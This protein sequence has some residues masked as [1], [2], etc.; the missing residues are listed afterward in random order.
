[1]AYPVG[2][3]FDE[4]KIPQPDRSLLTERCI[5][6]GIEEAIDVAFVDAGMVEE[7]L[8][9]DSGRMGG[10][11]LEAARRA[12]PMVAG[13]ARAG[14]LKGGGG[15]VVSGEGPELVQASRPRDPLPG[16]A[17]ST[18]AGAGG[19]TVASQ[20]TRAANPSVVRSS[21]LLV[22]FPRNA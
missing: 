9:E 5:T 19:P 15:G 10:V 16:R 13:W 20:G 11:L 18:V 3:L 4:M 2:K 21:R 7:I 22:S 1:M 8:G 17:P 14:A 6:A 12:K